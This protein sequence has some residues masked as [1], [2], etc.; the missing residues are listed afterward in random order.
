MAVKKKAAKKT[1][2]K[3]RPA[4]KG[5][6]RGMP[7]AP[8]GKPCTP[9]EICAYL[10]ELSVW[11]EGFIVD[12]TRLR[13]AVCNVEKKAWNIS[14]HTTTDRFCSHGGAGVEPQDPQKPPIWI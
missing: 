5:G 13:R 3:K 6:T 12:Y 11:L 2:A 4:K 9:P 14:G 1:V 10:K 7:E 8:E